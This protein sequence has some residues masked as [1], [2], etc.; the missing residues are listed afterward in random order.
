MK[1]GFTAE[2]QSLSETS[3]EA[4]GSGSPLPSSSS[5]P[6]VPL[7]RRKLKCKLLAGTL[8]TL[9][10]QVLH[11]RADQGSVSNGS[12]RDQITGLTQKITGLKFLDLC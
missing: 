9:Q 11:Y 5:S 12:G 4:A 6:P 7:M 8:R 3:T 2:T 1:A 10:G